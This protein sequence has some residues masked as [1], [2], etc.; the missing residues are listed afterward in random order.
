MKTDD[1]KQRDFFPGLAAAESKLTAVAFIR[2]D[3]NMKIVLD[4][5]ERCGPSGVIADTLLT[6]LNGMPYSSVTANFSRLERAGEIYYRGDSV[7]GRSN[8]QQRIIRFENRREVTIGFID[9]RRGS[10]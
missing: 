10:K 3:K 9:C 4:A 5:I 2:M 7:A 8:R 1:E 6:R